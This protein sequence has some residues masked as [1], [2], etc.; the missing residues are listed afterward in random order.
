MKELSRV[1]TTIGSGRDRAEAKVRISGIPCRVVAEALE[2]GSTISISFH[3]R[4]QLSDLFTGRPTRRIVISQIGREFF[5]TVEEDRSRPTERFRD[6][7]RALQRA[8]DLV[9]EL[10]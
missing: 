1:W 6:P 9:N 7:E 8:S 3:P 2:H 4:W 5:V 10:F